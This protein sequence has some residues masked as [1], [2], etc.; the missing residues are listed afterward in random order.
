M[1]FI[2]TGDVML[3]SLQ[4]KQECRLCHKVPSCLKCQTRCQGRGTVDLQTTSQGGLVEFSPCFVLVI[5]VGYMSLCQGMFADRRQH[6]LNVDTH[7]I[8]SCSTWD[9]RAHFSALLTQ[10]RAVFYC[11]A[12]CRRSRDCYLAIFLESRRESL[13]AMDRI[14]SMHI[15]YT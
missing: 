8:L 1:W 15:Y 12:C 7:N 2:F 11:M 3:I 5:T 4:H 14:I 6:N 9:G 13:R 10:P